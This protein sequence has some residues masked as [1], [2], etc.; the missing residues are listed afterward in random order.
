MQIFTQPNCHIQTQSK[1]LACFSFLSRNFASVFI[2]IA[3]NFRAHESI[4]E[5]DKEAFPRFKQTQQRIRNIVSCITGSIDKVA[6]NWKWTYKMDNPLIVLRHGNQLW[7]IDW[8]KFSVNAPN[9]KIK[10]FR[11]Q[12]ISDNSLPTVL[13][14]VIQ[15]Y[16]SHGNLTSY[17]CN[18]LISLI[19][20]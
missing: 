7:H 12:N 18:H 15:S 2:S 9:I 3:S 16:S 14:C 13:I 11:R 5:F 8:T 10:R 6:P 19:D 4:A 20:I 1:L 17:V